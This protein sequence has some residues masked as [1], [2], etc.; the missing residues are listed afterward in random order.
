MH[1]IDTSTAQKDKFGAGKNGFTTG[2][3]QLGIPAT[4][5]SAG[6]LDAIQEEICAVIE[7]K[8]SS[9]NLDKSNNTQLVAAIKNIIA[10]CSLGVGQTW[11]NVKANRMSNTTYTNTTGKPIMV[12]VQ[13]DSSAVMFNIN[14]L[15]MTLN[16]N[17]ND[18]GC[19]I[20]PVGATYS[21]T[22]NVI[23]TWAEL[24]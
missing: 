6:I 15:P 8:D 20:V 13:G 10:K 3:P 4:E 11:Q 5:I 9:I 16:E 18:Y 1:R 23:L 2:N 24:R 7:D 22:T 12:S 19:F 14:G 17:G 21:V